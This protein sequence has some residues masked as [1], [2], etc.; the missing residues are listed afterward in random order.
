MP[1]F[2][3]GKVVATPGLGFPTLPAPLLPDTT[4]SSCS[5]PDLTCKAALHTPQPVPSPR[6]PHAH[7]PATELRRLVPEVPPQAAA[8]SMLGRL[9]GR[10]P[11]EALSFLQVLWELLV[12]SLVSGVRMN[13]Q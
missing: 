2:R 8:Q 12:S 4:P 9:L 7:L 1:A 5:P 11:N 10:G 3:S 6:R 13:D